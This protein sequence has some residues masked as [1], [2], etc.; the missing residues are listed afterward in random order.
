MIRRLLFALV[1]GISGL[2]YAAPAPDTPDNRLDAASHL[3]DLPAYR[4]IATRQLYEALNSLPDEQHRRA[5]AALSDPAVM[6]SL[7]AVISRSMARTFST[8]ELAHLA[9]FLRAD[10]ARSMIDKTQYF[11]SAL[12]RE[13]LAASVSDP[14]LMKLLIGK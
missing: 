3:F 6:A 4:I 9:R 2:A 10:E 11:Q 13:L 5:L 12:T 7:R 8:S 1:L 14:E